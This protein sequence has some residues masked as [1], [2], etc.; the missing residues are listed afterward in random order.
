MKQTGVLNLKAGGVPER[1]QRCGVQAL[2]LLEVARAAPPSGHGCADASQ[3]EE[4]D[5]L[6]TRMEHL[7]DKG[8]VMVSV[9]RSGAH[10]GGRPGSWRSTPRAG[11]I[12]FF[13]P[14]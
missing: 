9:V 3:A 12:V 14:T 5:E 13:S 1:Y 11:E 7:G 2:V 8:V 10:P 4:N 6:Y